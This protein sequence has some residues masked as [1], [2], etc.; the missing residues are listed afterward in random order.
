MGRYRSSSGMK[1][2]R[3]FAYF[4]I[5][6]GAPRI[7]QPTPQPDIQEM[8]VPQ[9]GG[10]NQPWPQIWQ[11]TVPHPNVEE[12]R[13]AQGTSGANWLLPAIAVGTTMTIVLLAVLLTV[14]IMQGS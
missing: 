1:K 2:K 3:K 12:T 5:D 7:H 6:V 11:Q 9:L 13:N 4:S 10:A 8:T 14:V